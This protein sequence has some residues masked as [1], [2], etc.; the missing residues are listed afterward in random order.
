MQRDLQA[1]SDGALA[2]LAATLPMSAVMQAAKVAGLLPE[3]PPERITENALESAGVHLTE[4]ESN[5]VSAAAHLAFGAAAGALF[6][7]LHRRLPLPVPA[8]AHGVVFALG[9]YAASYEGWLPGLGLRPE[10][11][12]TPAKIRPAM[13]A[14]HVVYG[15]ALGACL[16]RLGA[17]E[18]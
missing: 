15:A 7:V 13:I 14:A 10:P 9:V 11:E 16:Q 3:H 2:G 18:H 1:L 8:A 12:E 17:M 4:R 5:V 6:G